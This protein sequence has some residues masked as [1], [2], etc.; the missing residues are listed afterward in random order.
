VAYN[1]LTPERDQLYLLAPSMAD[2]LPE[3]HL[4]WFVL[5]AV[6]EMDLS[7]FYADY[8]ADGWGGAAHDPS[9]MVALLLYAYCVGVRSSRQIER[10]CHVDVALRVICAGLLP[11]HTTVARFRQRHEE[12]LKTIFT[13]SLG[14]CS[15]AGMAGVGLVALER[16]KM[17]APASMQANVT[18]DTIDE[19][20][21]KMFAEAKAADESEDATFGEARGDE[22][23]AVLR[24]REDRRRRFKQAKEILDNELD[25]ERAAHEAH[26]ADPSGPSSPRSPTVTAL[27]A[28]TPVEPADI[29]R[30]HATG[31]PT[32][33]LRHRVL[34]ASTSARP[35]AGPSRFSKL[36]AGSS[37]S[38]TTADRSSGSRHRERARLQSQDAVTAPTRR[39]APRHPTSP[40]RSPG[41]ARLA[42]RYR[43]GARRP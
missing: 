32:T 13:S 42:H 15:K 14:L 23:P 34:L 24:G 28:V 4:A 17:A 22:P 12:A 20:V 18:K 8:R 41:R 25:A 5:D 40:R 10:A 39:Q 21:E 16:T 9:T 11:D 1:L 37:T 33:R 38:S 26:L 35:P 7:A 36:R 6:E 31:S 3:D 30:V 2:W 29:S 43:C 19:T 27:T